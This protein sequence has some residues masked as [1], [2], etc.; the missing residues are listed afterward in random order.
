MKRELKKKAFT[1]NY[2]TNMEFIYIQKEM[3][4]SKISAIFINDGYN[5][6]YAD[7]RQRYAAK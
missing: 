2:C 1:N 3:L 5:A 4:K 7:V 6:N